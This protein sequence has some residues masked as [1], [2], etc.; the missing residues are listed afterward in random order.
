MWLS[1]FPTSS[2][3]SSMPAAA[4]GMERFTAANTSLVVNDKTLMSGAVRKRTCTSG[5]N[6]MFLK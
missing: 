2:A 1:H 6:L 5:V 4:A 3:H